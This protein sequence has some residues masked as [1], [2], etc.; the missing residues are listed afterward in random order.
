MKKHLLIAY[1]IAVS[2]LV[3][4]PISPKATGENY[5]YYEFV[6]TVNTTG[7]N[8]ASW[9]PL[10]EVKDIVSGGY[11]TIE[12]FATIAEFPPSENIKDK[13]AMYAYIGHN[14]GGTSVFYKDGSVA[15]RSGVGDFSVVDAPVIGTSLGVSIYGVS[16]PPGAVKIKVSAYLIK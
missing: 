8:P 10:L 1:F 13:G 4:V 9:Y 3:A 15:L 14:M 16:L 6:A 11:K 12:V 5:A 7:Q 2:S